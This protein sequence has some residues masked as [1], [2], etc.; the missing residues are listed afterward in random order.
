MRDAKHLVS[1]HRLAND[2]P[3]LTMQ[4]L[5]SPEGLA[6][7]FLTSVKSLNIVK[8]NLFDL[9][10][11]AVWSTDPASIGKIDRTRALWPKAVSGE[12]VSKLVRNKTLVV[13]SGENQTTDIVGTYLPLQS[14]A[15]DLP[16]GRGCP[17]LL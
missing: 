8:F 2:D 3:M 14:S 1:G 5:V 11:V 7:T 13:L 9:N 10:G 17:A 6:S 15:D 12:V 16:G 4:D